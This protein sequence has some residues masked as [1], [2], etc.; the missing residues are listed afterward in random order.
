MNGLNDDVVGEF[1]VHVLDIGA[2]HHYF[3][4]GLVGRHE[5][6]ADRVDVIDEIFCA[7]EDGRL[8]FAGLK[9]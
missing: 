9:D 4:V 8:Y 5:F 6:L 3:R 7:P 1:G 2:E